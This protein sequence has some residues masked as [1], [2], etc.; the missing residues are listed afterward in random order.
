MKFLHVSD[1]HF[2]RQDRDNKATIRALK[3]VAQNY[4]DHHLVI[5]GDITDDGHVEQCY[6]AH[7]ALQR[8]VPKL[9]LSPGNHDFGFAGNL[10]ERRRARRFDRLISV[11]LQQNGKFAGFNR[12]VVNVVEED[13]TKVVLVSLDSNR[14]TWWIGDLACGRIGFWQRWHLKRILDRYP[15]AVRVVCFHHHPFVR[16][17]YLKMSDADKVMDALKGRAEIV[18]FGHRHS[19]ECWENKEAITHVLAAGEVSEEKTAWEITIK[20]RDISVKSVPLV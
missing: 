4:P 1:L 8:F 2:H 20:D 15:D 16:K 5:T 12:P 7:D 9:Y 17:F 13:G 6:R 3:F 10:Y 19:Q 14:E 18:M 11:P